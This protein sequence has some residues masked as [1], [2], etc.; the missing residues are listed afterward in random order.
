ME[1]IKSFASN[2]WFIIASGVASI[3]SLFVGGFTLWRV[4]IVFK[5][6]AK[7]INN[8]NQEQGIGNQQSGHNNLTM[9]QSGHNN[10]QARGDI[11][12]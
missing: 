12:G 7:E 11:K 8:I 6:K 1:L 5:Q 2:E 3:A 10:R 4:N 9:N